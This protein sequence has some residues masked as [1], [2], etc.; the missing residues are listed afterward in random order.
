EE[1][2]EDL[3]RLSTAKITE[4]HKIEIQNPKHNTKRYSNNET[5]EPICQDNKTKSQNSKRDIWTQN[6]RTN[7]DDK[8]Y[9][10][11]NKNAKSSRFFK[12]AIEKHIRET[13]S[14]ITINSDHTSSND[15]IE[16]QTNTN[17][18]QVK[19]KSNP[20]TVN[21]TRITDIKVQE[22]ITKNHMLIIN[23]EAVALMG[24]EL[25][26]E[27][28]TSTYELINYKYRPMTRFASGSKSK[29]K[30]FIMKLITNKLPVALN[31]HIR[32][33][34][35]F[36]NPICPRCMNEIEDDKHWLCCMA[37]ETR[38]REILLKSLDEW[39][40]KKTRRTRLI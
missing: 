14:K 37:N 30:A 6:S 38:I 12:V 29:I 25:L 40:K 3:K 1:I 15:Y 9:M 28:Y 20:T 21:P 27:L 22:L 11:S 13:K 19:Q 2:E 10:H 7:Y 39:A 17:R 24:N 34:E 5:H 32:Q 26:K 18:K 8:S 36:S 35:K 31:L 4:K 23:N 16:P 33:K